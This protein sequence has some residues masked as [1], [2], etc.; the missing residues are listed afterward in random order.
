MVKRVEKGCQYGRLAAVPVIYRKN[1]TTTT[2]IV[3]RAPKK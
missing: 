2:T 3:H 1:T